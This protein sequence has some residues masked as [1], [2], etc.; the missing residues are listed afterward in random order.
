MNELGDVSNK[1]KKFMN[2]WNRFMRSHTL[3][4]DHVL[5]RKCEEFLSIHMPILTQHDL[6]QQFM[7][8]LFN[9]WDNS[10]LPSSGLTVLMQRYDAYALD[11]KKNQNVTDT[12]TSDKGFDDDENITS[13]SSL[14]RKRSADGHSTGQ[15]KDDDNYC[16]VKVVKASERQQ[17]LDEN[18]CD[19]KLERSNEG[20]IANS[21][22]VASLSSDKSKTETY[23][24]DDS[25][26]EDSIGQFV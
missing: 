19:A 16:D 4:G 6:R 26:E 5:P 18:T 11:K 10:L 2:M 14:K 9:L 17:A 21:K 13:Q 1:E 3:V 15:A 25:R 12:G 20:P 7:L 22:H 23:G 8:H 24:A